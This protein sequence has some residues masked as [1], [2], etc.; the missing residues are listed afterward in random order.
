M[1]LIVIACS[2]ALCTIGVLTQHELVRICN[3]FTSREVCFKI[4]EDPIRAAAV[5]CMVCEENLRHENAWYVQP[6]LVAKHDVF[7]TLALIAY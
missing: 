4:M 5:A 7:N 6:R 1:V 2:A 3:R